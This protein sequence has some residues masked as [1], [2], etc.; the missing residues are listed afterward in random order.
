MTGILIRTYKRNNWLGEN[1]Y[2]EEE[3]GLIYD[4]L[5][6]DVIFNT[7]FYLDNLESMKT[8]RVSWHYYKGNTP[9]LPLAVV[10][11][12][13]VYKQDIPIL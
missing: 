13:R 12:K 5:L 1:G 10:K 8:F 2:S 11:K 9:V 7:R 3:Q 4:A 6:E